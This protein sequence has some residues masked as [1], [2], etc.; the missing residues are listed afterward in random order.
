MLPYELAVKY[1][2]SPIKAI[3]AHKLY[4]EGYS[5]TKIARLLGFTQPMVYKLLSTDV[6]VYYRKLLDI[7]FDDEEVNSYVNL[8]YSA[9]IRNDVP[10]YMML[11]T[12]IINKVLSSL[13]LCQLH[14]RVHRELPRDCSICRNLHPVLQLSPFIREYEECVRKIIDHIEAYKL[15]PEVGMNIVYA[16]PHAEDISDIIG[17]SGRIIRV[18]LIVEAVGKPCLGCSHHTASILLQAIKYN[19]SLR[20]AAVIRYSREFIEK[21]RS[22]GYRVVETGPHKSIKDFYSSMR[23]TIKK[24]RGRIDAIAD[25]GG[26]GL[27]PVIY[28]FAR[29]LKELLNK[30][31]LLLE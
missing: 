19:P 2:V 9:L 13:K 18:G 4:S 20:A 15:V 31:F 16:L 6:D 12:M 1:F 25:K 21:L 28:L 22:N 29:D 5:Q 3:I 24:Y 30:I 27:E 8:L 7:G 23:N 14:H 17:L 11:F 10:R 26:M